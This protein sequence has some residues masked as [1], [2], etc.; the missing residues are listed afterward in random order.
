MFLSISLELLILKHHVW[1]GLA[2][3]RVGNYGLSSALD[4]LALHP[5][6]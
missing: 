5:I 1:V 4:L 2:D 6:P 3:V